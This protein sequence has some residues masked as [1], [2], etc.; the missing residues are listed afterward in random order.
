LLQGDLGHQG[1]EA[2]SVLGTGCG[3]AQI[4]V[5]DLDSLIGPAQLAGT[6]T[7][8]VL[9]AEAFWIVSYL[10]RRRLSEV[11]DGL[12]GQMLGWNQIGT[13]HRSPPGRA[14]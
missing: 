3:E 7:Q 4:L 14:P 6:I 8:G 5:N 12:A 2:L 13:V 9:Q 1:I 11:N 10:M